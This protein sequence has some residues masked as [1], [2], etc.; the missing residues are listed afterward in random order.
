MEREEIM[1]R[2]SLENRESEAEVLLKELEKGRPLIVFDLETTG[3]KKLTDRILSFSA[4]KVTYD[5]ISFREVNRINQFINPE[6]QIP[7][8]VSNING[9]T[10]EMVADKPTED[11]A[12]EIIRG[13]IGENSIIAGYNSKNF[14]E[15]FI[16]AMYQRVFGENFSYDLHTDVFP[17]AKELLESDKYKLS[18]VAEKYGLDMGLTFHQSMDDVIATTR[19]LQLALGV[20]KKRIREKELGIEQPKQFGYFKIYNARLYAPSHKVERIYVATNPKTK[21]YYDGYKKEWCSDSDTI[22][23]EYVR[24]TVLSRESVLDEKELLK[25]LKEKEMEREDAVR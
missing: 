22:N 12:A 23:L 15:G 17:M 13:F 2:L 7:Q 3:L 21:T 25:K 18:V 24:K 9:I 4:V 16:D 14:D 11:E 1:S 5:G 19:V 10:N 20:Y 8:E 6:M